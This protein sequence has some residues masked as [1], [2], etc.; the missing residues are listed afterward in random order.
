MSFFMWSTSFTFQYLE[1]TLPKTCNRTDNRTHQKTEL[2]PCAT[3]NGA[4]QDKWLTH[5]LVWPPPL[6][7][8]GVP[9]FAEEKVGD[10]LVPHVQHMSLQTI[11][12]QLIT[13]RSLFLK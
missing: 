10:T 5:V 11:P 4:S 2:K 12:T 9:K 7:G 6:V 1:L 3:A 8:L 13:S